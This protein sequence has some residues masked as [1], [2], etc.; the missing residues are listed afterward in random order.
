[1]KHQYELGHT[2]YKYQKTTLK[3]QIIRKV[4]LPHDR[5]PK[6][7]N[8]LRSLSWALSDVYNQR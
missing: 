4:I 7:A 1:M 2:G 5:D 3:P 8:F 6:L